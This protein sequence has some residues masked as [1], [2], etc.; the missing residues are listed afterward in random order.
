M[1]VSRF[2]V[3]ITAA[4]LASPQAYA[5]RASVQAVAAQTTHDLLPRGG[6]A[7]ASLTVPVRNRVGLAVLIERFSGDDRGAGFAC[8]GLIDPGRCPVEPLDRGGSRFTLG[9]GADVSLWENRRV[10]FAVLPHV[11]V[12]HAAST[13][14]GT[15]SG[16]ELRA[17][18]TELGFSAALESRFT[19]SARMP[20]S[21]IVGGAMRRLGPVK[22]E[23]VVDGYTPFDRWY[24]ARVLYVGAAAS[25]RS[26][27]E[28]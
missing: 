8:A 4:C 25:W 18:K 21:V 27:G 23:V 20:L 28:P 2:L 5:Q 11:L 22:T 3:G 26:R 12:A 10:E 16:N 9:V 15:S 7:G 13:V 6:G 17:E 19:P 1:P 24:S 14:R